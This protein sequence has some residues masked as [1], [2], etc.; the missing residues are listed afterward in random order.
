MNDLVVGHFLIEHFGL[1]R[2]LSSIVEAPTS[3]T[4]VLRHM[5]VTSRPIIDHR[6]PLCD[7]LSFPVLFDFRMKL[8]EKKHHPLDPPF[9]S[10]YR[11]FEKSL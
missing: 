6:P 3:Y 2:Q 7:G 1:V 9:A 10:M 4:F 11:F 5:C 8:E